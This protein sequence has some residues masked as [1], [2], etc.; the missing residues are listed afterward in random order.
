MGLRLP[1]AQYWH[2]WL[3]QNTTTMARILQTYP[4]Q[5]SPHPVVPR[6]YGKIT[7]DTIPHDETP[8]AVPDCILRVQQFVGII[9]YY[10]QAVDMTVLTALTTLGSNQAKATTNTIKSTNHLLDYLST[11]SIRY[12]PQH[13]LGCIICL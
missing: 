7:Q 12:G 3:H 8:T 9:L 2:A 1:Y 6:K 4:P 11:L 5:H 10:A 13:L